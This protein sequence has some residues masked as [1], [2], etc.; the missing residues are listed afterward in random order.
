MCFVDLEKAFD[1]VPRGIL[2]GVLHEYGVRGPLLRAVPVSVRP[3]QELGSHCRQISRRSQGPEGV[4]FGNHWEEASGKT[5]DTLER[6]CSLSW[7]GNASGSPL[8]ELEEVSG[9]SLTSWF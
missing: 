3:E 5:Q 1:R 7:P 6:L 2:W 9:L 8:E 4:R